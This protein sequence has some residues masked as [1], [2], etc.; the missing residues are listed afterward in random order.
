L[1]K[2]ICFK[3]HKNFTS[4]VMNFGIESD[5]V[6]SRIV[7]D[8]LD[9]VL[10]SVANYVDKAHFYTNKIELEKF[11]IRLREC[12]MRFTRAVD[13]LVINKR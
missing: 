4:Q 5:D 2:S 7:T 10:M 9:Q 3:E 13:K 6:N 11:Q 8:F 1:C 12:H